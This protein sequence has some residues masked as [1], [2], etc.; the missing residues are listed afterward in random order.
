M[1]HRIACIHALPQSIGPIGKAFK[2]LWPEAETFNVMDDHLSIDREKAGSLTPELT[3]RISQ[4]A[5]YGMRSRATGILFTCSAF[6][7]AI[8]AV[9]RWASMP[10]LRPNEAMF[11]EAL[12]RGGKIAMLLT[13]QPSVASMEEEF[14]AQRIARSAQGKESAK[15]AELTALCVPDAM[16]A[17][18]KGDVETHNRLLAEATKGLDAELIMLGQF[19]MAPAREAVHS[20]SGQPVLTSPDCAVRRLKQALRPG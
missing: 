4:L 10:V 7:E 2:E 18:Q 16:A 1:T 5:R 13:F 3:E 15:P 12:E 9:A 20:A 11:D 6:G 14:K 8:E 17:L 19:S